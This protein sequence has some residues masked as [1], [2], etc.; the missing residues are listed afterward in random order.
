MIRAW[1]KPSTGPAAAFAAVLAASLP[2]A[3]G[4][5]DAG[6]AAAAARAETEARHKDDVRDTSKRGH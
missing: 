6:K 4:K 3:R 1:D 5:G 2:E